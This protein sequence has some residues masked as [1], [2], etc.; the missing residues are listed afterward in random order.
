M[1]EAIIEIKDKSKFV[2]PL[3]SLKNGITSIV[4]SVEN[5]TLKINALSE[6]RSQRA[7]IWYKSDIV[8]VSKI[9]DVEKLGIYNLS[10][11]LGV[12]SLC[13]SKLKIKVKDNKLMIGL[14]KTSKVNYVLS[15]ID[16]IEEGPEKSKPIDFEI[17]FEVDENFICK[18]N[19]ISK[20]LNVNILK[21][22]VKK[23]KLFYKI[24]DK[25]EESHDFTEKLLDDCDC[26]D[27]S[28]C[29]CLKDE[30]RDNIGILTDK[31]PYKFS[32]HKKIVQIESITEDYEKI[33]YF[34]GPLTE[35]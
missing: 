23:G 26:S 16:L 28:I 31:I 19:S 9:D 22:I 4:F 24:T 20:S 15:D 27:I 2:A 3:S 34:L 8:E 21:F 10:E 11:F 14:G 18:V 25:N 29:I 35:D 1:A 13:E 33:R 7:N 12:L 30:N 6:D 5:N 17:E 32:L